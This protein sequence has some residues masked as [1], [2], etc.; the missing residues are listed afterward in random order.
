VDF[1]LF[2]RVKEE[3][4]DLSLGRDSLKDTLVGVIGTFCSD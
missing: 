1:F 4:M 2:W 3:L